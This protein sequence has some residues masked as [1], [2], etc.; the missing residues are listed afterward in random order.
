MIFDSVSPG[1]HTS[2]ECILHSKRYEYV[3]VVSRVHEAREGTTARTTG[4]RRRADLARDAALA[5]DEHADLELFS[6]LQRSPPRRASVH[7]AGFAVGRV[8][9]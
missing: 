4:L 8:V 6:G 2:L 3:L 1:F 7:R 9:S 5:D